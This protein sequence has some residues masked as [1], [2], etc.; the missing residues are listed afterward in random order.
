MYI[1]EKDQHG[2]FKQIVKI[3]E[4]SQDPAK[5]TNGYYTSTSLDL[6]VDQAQGAW[7]SADFSFPYPI[8]IYSAEWVNATTYADDCFYV[9]ID[10]LITVGAITSDV[11]VNDTVISVQ[12]TVTDN[13]IPGFYATLDDG[14]NTFESEVGGVD[15]GAGTITLRTASDTAFAAVTPTYVKLTYR[16]A[17]MIR[18][19]G[20]GRMELGKDVIGGSFVGSNKIIRVWYQNNEGTAVDKIFSVVIEYKF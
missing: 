20:T 11:A 6:T 13:M 15:S 7:K 2:N 5:Q 16:M 3:Q 4:E 8:A 18:L 14:T 19:S 12:S 9:E 17:R 10:P 1:P